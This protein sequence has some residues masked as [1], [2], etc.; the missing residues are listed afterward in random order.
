[1]T[2]V[3]TKVTIKGG[4]PILVEATVLELE[5]HI[6]SEI[7]QVDLFWFNTGKPTTEQFT[8]SLTEDDWNAVY[9]AVYAA[10]AAQ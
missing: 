7:D 9:D 2:N 5:P 4:M 8:A 1:M 6:G 3:H 10:H